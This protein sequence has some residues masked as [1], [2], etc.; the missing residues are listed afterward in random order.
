MDKQEALKIISMIADGLN[1]YL[2]NNPTENPPELNPIT[3]RALCC[4]V[5]SLIKQQD[6]EELAAAYETKSIIE[7]AD[8]F[9]GPLRLYLKR[10]E[11]ALIVTALEKARFN[12]GIAATE[13]GINKG[14]MWKKII[15]Y[16]LEG[17]LI[18]KEQL[19]SGTGFNLEQLLSKIETN[20]ILEALSKTDHNKNAAADLLG[21]TFRSLRYRI[22]RHKI[23]SDVDKPKTDYLHLYKIESLEEF[24]NGIEKEAI[25]EALKRANGNKTEAAELL[26]ITF[27]SMRYRCEQ[28]GIG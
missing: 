2:E 13:L 9:E 27:R 12:E 24:M 3:V 17:L 23:P 28:I 6:K 8:S 26:G 5:A 25:I 1:P 7:L 22:E 20:I 14:T 10:K 4:A 18:I 16:K 19:N 15:E 21:M 11:R